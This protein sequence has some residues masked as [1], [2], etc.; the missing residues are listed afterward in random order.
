MADS[1]F[2]FSNVILFGVT[3]ED[4]DT[5]DRGATWK[6]RAY[7]EEDVTLQGLPTIESVTLDENDFVFVSNNQKV[8]ENGVYR[9]SINNWK[10]VDTEVGDTIVPRNNGISLLQDYKKWEHVSK[11]MFELKRTRQRGVRRRRG[12]NGQLEDQFGPDAR[13]ARIYGFSFDGAYYD[14]ARPVVFLVHGVGILVTDPHLD[15]GPI[16]AARRVFQN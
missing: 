5:V 8:K 7:F 10:P 12:D 2:S 1:I 4:L 15:A 3:M 9:V 16:A 6:V 11:G 13:F 14:L